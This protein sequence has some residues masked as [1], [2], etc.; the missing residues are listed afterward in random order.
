MSE[1]MHTNKSKADQKSSTS[2]HE[3]RQVSSSKRSPGTRD[4]KMM[5]LQRT[6]GNQ[7]VG[8]MLHSR[9]LQAD[10]AVQRELDEHE[11][12]IPIQPKLA[13]S[14]PGDEYEQEADRVADKVMRT[15]SGAVFG[16]DA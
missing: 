1:K 15:P 2:V 14:Q 13:I 4:Y 3:N 6:I 16:L 5:Q 8:R 7:A 10:E 11:E 9:S 12:I